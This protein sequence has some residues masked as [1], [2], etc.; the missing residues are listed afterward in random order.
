MEPGKF[1]RY[2]GGNI[3]PW[4]ASAKAVTTNVLQQ[5]CERIAKFNLKPRQKVVILRDYLIPKVLSKLSFEPK[6]TKGHQCSLDPVVRYWVKKW[7]KLA[8]DTLSAF[9]HASAKVG[10][11]GIPRLSRAAF[12]IQGIR[13]NASM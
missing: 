3:G 5:Y 10:G 8:P 9:I 12:V 4:G 1:N 7:L 13:I 2:L 11:L 6:L